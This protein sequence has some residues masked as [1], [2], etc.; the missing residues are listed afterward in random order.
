MNEYLKKEEQSKPGSSKNS[1]GLN[2]HDVPEVELSGSSGNLRGNLNASGGKGAAFFALSQ[3]ERE[4][5]EL[6]RQQ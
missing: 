6:H 3:E 5:N 4:V 2:V 1:R